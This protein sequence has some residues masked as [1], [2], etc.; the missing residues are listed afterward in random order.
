LV[1]T[2]AI[3]T[4]GVRGRFDHVGFDGRNQL[5]VAALGNDSVEVI[6]ISA[7]VR[8]RSISGIPSPQGVVHAPDVKKLF[9]ASSKGKLRIFDGSNFDLIKEIDFHEDADSLRYDAATH[10]VYVGYGEDETGAIGMVDAVSNERL[11]Q[12]YQLGA[13][14]EWFQLEL[15][16]PLRESPGPQAD[17]CDQSQNGNNH[18]VAAHSGAQFPDGIG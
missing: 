4:P 18:A 1:L 16:S 13:H 15:N 2:E 17:R 11:K 7:R 8:V 10:R 9:V 14:P 6:D 12:E 5:F 3:P